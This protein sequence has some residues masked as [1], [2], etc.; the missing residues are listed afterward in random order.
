M[1]IFI[2]AGQAPV[3]AQSGARDA[4]LRIGGGES[5]D[6][7]RG[8]LSRVAAPAVQIKAVLVRDPGLM[9]EL[10][11]W[12]AKEAGDNG[13]VVDDLAVSDQGIFERLDQDLAFRSVATRL[14]Q[15][16]GYL[17]P[18]LN[19]DSDKGKENEL[20]IRERAKRIVAREEQEDAAASQARAAADKLEQA[21]DCDGDCGAGAGSGPAKRQRANQAPAPA[22]NSEPAMPQLPVLPDSVSPADLA[23]TLRAASGGEDGGE[24]QGLYGGSAL[25]GS[26]IGAGLGDG[27]LSGG[28][29]GTGS[30]GTGDGRLSLTSSPMR[31]GDDNG[32]AGLSMQG[33]AGM[34]PGR[35]P[36]LDLLPMTSGLDTSRTPAAKDP[37][38]TRLPGSRGGSNAAEMTPV[39]MEHTLGPYSDVP[40]LYDLY[41]QASPRDRN[42]QRFG[43]EMFRNG[44]REEQG[45][46]MDLPVGPDYVVGPGDGLAIDLW[47]GFSQRFTRTVD[48]EGRIMLP[49]AGTAAGERA[50]AGRCAGSGAAR[51]AIAV[52]GCVG[53]CFA[54]EI[55]DGADLCSGRSGGAGGV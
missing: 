37:K 30:L 41:V 53:G 40:S 25:G 50:D 35:N 39:A 48:R 47:G 23:R 7:V 34:N 14:L 49:E 1:F 46:P 31:R 55:A 38:I 18:Q 3:L 29:L 54:V 12:V 28:G 21:S 6:L 42:L 11:G 10:K 2:V 8:N 32:G 36:L 24:S 20:V 52:S 22:Q 26:M 4:G 51:V 16:Y 27:G 44:T 9:V 5:S 43:L 33:M 15:R 17:M 13:Q 19:P 45:V